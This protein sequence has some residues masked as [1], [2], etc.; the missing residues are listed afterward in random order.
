M[1]IN[2]TH[3]DMC[4]FSTRNQDYQDL[5]SRLIDMIR[6][7][8]RP[9]TP[10]AETTDPRRHDNESEMDPSRPSGP[11]R[12]STMPAA[13]SGQSQNVE[14]HVH[15][16]DMY[17]PNPQ[18]PRVSA[19]TSG[20]AQSKTLNERTSLN[21]AEKNSSSIDELVLAQ[22]A[23]RLS[24]NPSPSEEDI[25]RRQY[26]DGSDFSRLASFDTVFIIDD[27]SSMQA[28]AD[29]NNES[30]FS[31]DPVQTRW[32]LLEDSFR[33]VAGKA[34]EY[35]KGKVIGISGVVQY[36]N[37]LG[38]WGRCHIPEMRRSVGIEY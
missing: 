15:F 21:A 20:K 1:K 26:N 25:T 7:T 13:V 10:S 4:K 31:P 32:D 6:K 29:S 2:G 9:A 17:S 3:V 5:E 23:N 35:D 30:R 34:I 12:A 18:L 27:T 28:P 37:S 8:I 33:H 36:T 24:L 11:G 14:F 19:N 16:P 22:H 38:R